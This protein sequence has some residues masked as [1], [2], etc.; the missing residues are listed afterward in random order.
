MVAAPPP[1]PA[2]LGAFSDGQGFPATK[3]I[4]EFSVLICVNVWSVLYQCVLA[5]IGAGEQ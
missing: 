4:V 1:T 3:L 2:S 5:L